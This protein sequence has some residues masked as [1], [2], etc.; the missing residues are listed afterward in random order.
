MI[1]EKRKPFCPLFFGVVVWQQHMHM[2]RVSLHGSCSSCLPGAV[3]HNFKFSKSWLFLRDVSLTSMFVKSH[4]T[5]LQ[6]YYFA[7]RDLCGGWGIAFLAH[8]LFLL[9][10]YN[11]SRHDWRWGGLP[12]WIVVQWPTFKLGEVGC[13]CSFHAKCWHTFILDLPCLHA[14]AITCTSLAVCSDPLV[15]G[16]IL[17]VNFCNSFRRKKTAI[18]GERQTSP[19]TLPN[20]GVVLCKLWLL[21]ACAVIGVTCM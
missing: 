20:K 14:S 21:L 11:V 6:V 18:V 4:F 19:M 15:T 12:I 7:C 10:R 3:H 2:L 13:P 16:S 1:V 5:G 9:R 8:F 17:L